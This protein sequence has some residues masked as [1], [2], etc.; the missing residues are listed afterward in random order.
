MR[1]ALLT[2]LAASAA[3]T[4]RAEVKLHPL[5]CDHMV[6]QR[7]KDSKVFG[8][9]AAGEAVAV[10]L[11][12][13]NNWTGEAKATADKDGKWVAALA[14]PTAGLNYTLTATGTDGKAV[15]VNDVAVGDVWICS[16]QSNMEWKVNGLRKDNQAEKVAAQAEN[17]A[18]RLFTLQRKVSPTPIRT[19]AVTKTEGLWRTCTPESV[20]DFSAVGYFFG[21]DIA[22]AEKVPVGLISTNW[23]GTPAEA[24]TSR[25]ALEAESV[26]K[27]YVDGLDKLL[28]ANADPKVTEAKYKADLAKWKVAA[29]K[30]KAE[31][32][33]APRAPQKPAAGGVGPNSPSALYNGMIAPLLPVSV[34]GAIW[35]QGESNAGRAKEYRT[36]MPTMILDW[37]EKFGQKDL[38]FFM[39]QLAPY[40]N[41]NADRVEY[42]ELRDAQYATTLKLPKVGIAVITDA[43]DLGDIHP[44]KKEPAGR[45]L[46]LAARAIA[47]GDQVEFSG[48]VYKPNSLAVDGDKATVAFTHAAGLATAGKPG[49]VHGFTVCGDDK[50][51]HPATAVIEGETV[52]VKCDKVSKPV[53]VRYGW[54]NFAKPELNLTNAAGIPAVPF[55]TDD[56]PLTTK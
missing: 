9:A 10:K 52:V 26:L 53:A 49:E 5:F 32:K 44:Q 24:W 42:A 43:G 27:Y 39:V 21:R 33:K 22:A 7:G 4:A 46:A 20:M 1:L 55:R 11:T 19:L 3:G 15:T 36:L 18:I 25:G 34:K 30:A 23:G 6:L 28:A 2:L 56:F 14:A 37:R 47:Y 13:A 38:P 17:P 35:Y 41:G 8:T 45:R 48:P 16:G 51:F 54:V 40:G 12:A 50:V 31:N 29:D